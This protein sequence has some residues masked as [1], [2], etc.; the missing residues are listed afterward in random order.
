MKDHPEVPEP[1]PDNPETPKQLRES[2][3]T[4]PCQGGD[5]L[6]TYACSSSSPRP[7]SSSWFSMK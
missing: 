1:Q 4:V 5:R 7:V 3:A 6:G 2:S